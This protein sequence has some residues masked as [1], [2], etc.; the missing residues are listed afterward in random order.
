MLIVPAILEKEREMIEQKV[1]SAR[2]NGLNMVQIDIADGKFVPNTTYNNFSFIGKLDIGIEAHLMVV[3]P[4]EKMEILKKHDNTKKV[5]IHREALSAN[6][7]SKLIRKKEKS[8]IAINPATRLEDTYDLIAN[9]VIEHILFMGVTPGFSGK[10][11]QESVLDK[12]RLFNHKIRSGITSA[13]DGGVN[14]RTAKLMNEAGVSWINASS[15]IWNPDGTIN[16]INLA[17]LKGL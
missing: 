7:I 12:I 17:W 11:F 15:F 9:G 13:V 8:G 10:K 6:E 16:R 5:I 14:E 3:D 4:L 1:R 2:E